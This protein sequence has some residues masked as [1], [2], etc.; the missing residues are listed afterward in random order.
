M[1][2]QMYISKP[3]NKL[4][5]SLLVCTYLLTKAITPAGLMISAS[6]DGSLSYAWCSG[7]LNSAQLAQLEQLTL[8]NES[9]STDTQTEHTD[10][11]SPCSFSLFNI[12]SL[13][14]SD[15]RLEKNPAGKT[16]LL[17]KKTETRFPPSIFTPYYHVHLL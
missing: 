17:V 1:I 16:Y 5:I 12:A 11:E 14:H 3:S 9:S 15:S 10:S 13:Y 8:N 6:E 2:H 4:L 7:D